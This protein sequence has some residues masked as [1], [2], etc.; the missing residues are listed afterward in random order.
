MTTA[1]QDALRPILSPPQLPHPALLRADW[2]DCYRLRVPAR[3]D[4]TAEDVAR[5]ALC[6]FPPWARLLLRLRDT[7]MKPFGLHSTR[8]LAASHADRI[9]F[10]PMISRTDRQV[11]VGLD[12]RH[13]DF[14]LVIDVLDEGAGEVLVSFT[15]LV[16]RK[17]LLG[18][19]Y[20]AAITP[21]HRLI[22]QASLRQVRQCLLAQRA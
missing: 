20:I 18:R 21:F 4:L 11:V 17:V 12:D 14:R 16:Y 19:I 6:W 8:E 1:A 2:A 7:L 3:A 9:G 10:F 5:L 15:T 13:L 22:V